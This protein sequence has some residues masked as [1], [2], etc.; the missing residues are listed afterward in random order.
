M[1]LHSVD[2]ISVL[3]RVWG[4]DHYDEDL[5][6]LDHALQCAAHARGASAAPPLIAAAL[7]HD[8]GHLLD[9]KGGGS[10][11]APLSPHH[12]DVGAAAL[13]GLFPPTVTAPIALHVRAKRYLAAVEPGYIDALSQGSINSLARQGGPMGLEE[14]RT[15]EGNPGFSDACSLRRWDDLGKVDGL[16]VEPFE[17]YLD[18]LNDLAAT[19]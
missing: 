9:L 8:I 1:T 6:Q 11:A 18:L 14:L 17:T 5:T 16:E 2:Q 3:Y 7:L 4:P 19:D 15:F 10:V 12:A 13:A